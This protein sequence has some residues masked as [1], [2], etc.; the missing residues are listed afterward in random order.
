MDIRNATITKENN[1]DQTH[2]MLA[3]IFDSELFVVY[4]CE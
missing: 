3:V 2:T 1:I 4:V